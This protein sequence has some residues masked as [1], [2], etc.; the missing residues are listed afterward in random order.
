MICHYYRLDDIPC[1]ILERQEEPDIA[2][3]YRAGIGFVPGPRMEIEFEGIPITRDE[4]NTMIL[5]NRRPQSS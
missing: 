2:E 4:F 3:M 1:R 5:S